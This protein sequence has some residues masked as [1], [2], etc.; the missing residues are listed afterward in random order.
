MPESR[1]RKRKKGGRRPTVR[2]DREPRRAD[3]P[4]GREELPPVDGIVRTIVRGGREL[5]S[6][7]DPFEVELWA[8]A[9][10]GTTYKQPLPLDVRERFEKLVWDGVLTR[11]EAEGSPAS[12]A[13]LRA[14]AAVAEEPLAGRAAGTADR[15]TARGVPEPPWVGEIGAAAF[16]RGWTLA[17]VYR[18]QT[19]YYAHFRY[20]GRDEHLVSAL[21][22]ENLGGIVKDASA[23]VL[24]RDPRAAA[25]RAPDAVVADIDPGTLAS[26]VRSAI[27]SGDLYLDND[28]TEDFKELRALL[29]ARMR[30]LPEGEA[31]SVEPLDDASREA[32]VEEFLTRPGAPPD[33]EV[34]RGVLDHCLTA[35]CDFGDGDAL[36][37]SPTVVEMFLL[38][39]LPRKAT[40][41]AAQ[42]RAMPDVLGAW[43]AFCLERR[44]LEPRW[45]EETQATV[46]EL[47]PEF[48]QAVTDQSSFGSG[49][50]IEYAMLADGVDLTDEGAVQDWIDAFNARPFE[51][52]DEFLSGSL[53]DLGTRDD[54]S[55]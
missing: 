36:R 23:G 46:D 42:I 35:R 28:W 29:L 32:L 48:R 10:L 15:V 55:G 24:A 31:P 25:E 6:L 2:P 21:Y 54:R 11:A 27:A 18:D 45:I 47:M 37:W 30:L 33:D 14:L 44:G 1:G 39:F 53:P 50:R 5:L 7:E 41:D 9:V 26:A 3:P 34:T 4:R 12:L 40:V 43:V 17:D 20:P 49:K 8:S 38:D 13:V 52:R 16:V 51:E 19:A 22:D